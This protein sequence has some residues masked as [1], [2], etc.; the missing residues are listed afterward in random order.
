MNYARGFSQE[1]REIKSEWE[2]SPHE[3]M[4]EQ[5]RRVDEYLARYGMR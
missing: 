2:M 3:R 4:A 5:R 1:A